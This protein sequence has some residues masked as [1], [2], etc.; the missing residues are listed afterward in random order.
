[1]MAYKLCRLTKNKKITSLFINNKNSLPFNIWL[2]AES[3]PTKGYKLR[4][5]WHCTSKPYAPHLSEKERV[6]VKVEIKNYEKFERPESQG[7]LWFL[8]KNIKLLEIINT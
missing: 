3:H 1:M 6:W 7:G 5:F 8:A 4:P 2:K